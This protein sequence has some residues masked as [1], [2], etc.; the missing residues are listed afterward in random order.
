MGS[1]VIDPRKKELNRRRESTKARLGMDGL[2]WNPG[3]G[4]CRV[5]KRVGRV[6]G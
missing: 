5:G 2:G 1:R 3:P 4:S 6:G